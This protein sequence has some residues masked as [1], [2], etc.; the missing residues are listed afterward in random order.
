[1]KKLLTTFLMPVK[2]T[3]EKYADVSKSLQGA[4]LLLKYKYYGYPSISLLKNND[5]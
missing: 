3:V 5:R 2:F 4:V 1:M